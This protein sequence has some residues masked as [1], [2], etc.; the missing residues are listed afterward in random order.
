MNESDVIVKREQVHIRFQQEV[1]AGLTLW[2]NAMHALQK[3][4]LP[5]ILPSIGQPL[6]RSCVLSWRGEI[7]SETPMK[8]L[9]ERYGTPLVAVH[10]A[11]LL[12]ALLKAVGESVVRSGVAC[13]GFRQ[14]ETGVSLQLASGEEMTGDL[15]VGADGINSSIRGHLFGATRPR[16]AG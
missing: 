5:D 15:L 14:D 1:G 3:L 9:A 10:R 8:V 2:A 7:L 16:Y 6:T 13:T 4:G 11:D 12:A